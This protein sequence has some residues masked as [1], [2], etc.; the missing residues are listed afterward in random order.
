[1]KTL[2]FRTILLGFL[3]LSGCATSHYTEIQ[4][5]RRVYKAD[6]ANWEKDHG[7]KLQE[8]KPGEEYLP[9]QEVMAKRCKENP[10]DCNP[11]H[12]P[13]H[14]QNLEIMWNVYDPTPDMCNK[15]NMTPR[16]GYNYAN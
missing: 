16:K 9:L 12:I 8:R 5:E 15:S 11:P 14:L 3:G 2:I 1:M 4:D 10:A 6:C 7:P 13:E